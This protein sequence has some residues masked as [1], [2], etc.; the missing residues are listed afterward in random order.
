VRRGVGK[1][2]Q[3]PAETIP[4]WTNYKSVTWWTQELTI[5]RKR[6]NALRTRYQRTQH[7]AKRELQKDTTRKN[8]GI[9]SNKK[10]SYML[11]LHAEDII[12]S[13]IKSNYARQLFFYSRQETFGPDC[14][15][16]GHLTLF[17]YLLFGLVMVLVES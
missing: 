3:A 8:Q 11:M 2:G 10:G 15:T 13:N 4:K 16:A 14:V 17:D 9:S 6:L 7:K 1:S 5:K 12:R